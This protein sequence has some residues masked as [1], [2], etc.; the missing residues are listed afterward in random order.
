MAVDKN[1]IGHSTGKS[2]L[3]VER[4]PLSAFAKSV[5]DDNPIYHNPAA[6]QAAGFRAIPAPPTYGFVVSYWGGFPEIQPSEDPTGGRNII[7]EVVGGLMKTGGVILHGEQEFTY[8]RPILTGDVLT[9]EGKVV[10]LY[11]RESKGKTMTF[12][13]T[14]NVYRNQ[15]TGEPVL[16]T[17][18]NLIHRR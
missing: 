4:G 9:C 14:E 6:A 5:K 16:T 11:E 13:V 12:L 10:D 15:K 3:V 1:A 17:R 7:M 2:T 18:M 8:H